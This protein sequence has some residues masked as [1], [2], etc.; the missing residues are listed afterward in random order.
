MNYDI[1]EDIE[2]KRIKKELLCKSMSVPFYIWQVQREK[3]TMNMI[4]RQNLVV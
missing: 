4:M 1:P 2:T 3:K